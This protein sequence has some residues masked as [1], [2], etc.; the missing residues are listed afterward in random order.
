MR[1]VGRETRVSFI[2]QVWAIDKG[3]YKVGE[4]GN[5]PGHAVWG[6]ACPGRSESR[7]AGLPRWGEVTGGR[8]ACTILD[9]GRGG[10]RREY[11]RLRISSFFVIVI[12]IIVVIF[13]FLVFFS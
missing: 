8:E 11:L 1:R 7:Q 2:G 6:R 13:H 10:S 5:V 12:V 9:R 4:I 3:E